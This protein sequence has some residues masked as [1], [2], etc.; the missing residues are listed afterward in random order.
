M[1]YTG[2]IICMV[3]SIQSFNISSQ[4]TQ[5]YNRTQIICHILRGKIPVQLVF[6]NYMILH[7]A[8]IENY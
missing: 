7:T 5:T 6:G 2:P 3:N 8:Y 1:S 4:Y